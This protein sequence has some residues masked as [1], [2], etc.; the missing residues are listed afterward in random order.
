MYQVSDSTAL[1]RGHRRLLSRGRAE[2]AVS[3][4]VVLLGLTSLLTDISS[5]MVVAVL[6]LY[7]VAVGGFSPLAFGVIDGLYNGATAVVRL[8]S[9]FIGDRFDRHK[10]VAAAGYGL[11][12]ICKLLL[13]MVGTAVSAIGAVVLLDRTG[14]GIRTAPRDAMISLSTP[15]EQLGTAFGVHRA[16]DT[17]GAMLGPLVAFGLL[18]LAP[19]AFDSV[20][21]VS[22]CIALLGVGVLVLF[23][24]GRART[25]D[26]GVPE[27]RPSLRGAFGLL[28]QRRFRALLAAGAA[29]S[30][31]TASDA[32][33]F[34]ALQEQ[35]DLGNSLFPLLFVGS[36][37]TFMVLAVPMGRLAD[38]FGRGRVLLGGYALL[39]VVYARPG[40]AARRLAPARGGARAARRVLRGDGRR[41][42]GPRQQ[43]DPRGD[44][45]QRT[46]A[47]RHRHE[48]RPAGRLGRVRRAVDGLGARRGVRGVR[49]RPRGRGCARGLGAPSPAGARPCLSAAARSSSRVLCA[50]CVLGAAAAIASGMRGQDGAAPAQA[51]TELP[52]AQAAGRA[53]VLFRSLGGGAAKGRVAV[54]PLA[55]AGG[56]RTDE[57]AELRPRLLRGQGAGICLARGKGFAAGYRARIF[58]PDMKRTARARRSRASRAA[59][60]CRPT[61][62]TAPSRCSS[63]ATPTPPRAP[64]RPR[65][66]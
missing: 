20:F 19:L 55:E 63:R 50:A 40:G 45:R 15:K 47:A 26:A 33:I 65:R 16:M 62:A 9:G 42:H 27:K 38:R 49:R 44:P 25:P 17:T 4:T 39:L 24:R 46:R 48:P 11:S 12:A 43:R 29:L 53:T 13:L 66:R 32:F 35:L 36:A 30:L 22:F 41:A 37:G 18:A 28:G 14:K 56:R 54:A 6:P 1:L 57:A 52:E 60:A 8:A 64:S 58:G 31:A 7:L 5:E 51:R 34:L 61:A 3:R 2:P 21:L 59:R 23:V 10:E